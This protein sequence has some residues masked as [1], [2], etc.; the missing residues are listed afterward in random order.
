MGYLGSVVALTIATICM[1]HIDVA[2]FN[3]LSVQGKSVYIYT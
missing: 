1:C 2:K 3:N